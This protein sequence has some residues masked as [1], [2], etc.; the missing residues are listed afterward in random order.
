[1]C[2]LKRLSRTVQYICGMGEKT[3]SQLTSFP[4]PET[5]A[6]ENG[7][8]CN[9]SVS[10]K[11]ESPQRPKN[12]TLE[13]ESRGCFS[14]VFYSS[15]FIMLDVWRQISGYGIKYYNQDKFPVPQT[16]LVAA[17]ELI[18]CF[19]F[20]VKMTMAGTICTVKL[21]P[22]YLIPSLCYAV[23]NNL[24]YLAMYYTTPPVWN[25]L[26]QM[27]VIFTAFVY[28]FYFKKTFS[29]VQWLALTL[30]MVAIVMAKFTGESSGSEERSRNMFIAMLMALGA[31]MIAAMGPVYAEYLLKNDDR[32][33]EEQQLQMYLFGSVCTCSLL[34]AE[35]AIRKPSIQLDQISHLVGILVVLCV[36]FSVACGISTA[37]IMKKL[38]NIVKL[39]SQAIS[40]SLTT[41]ACVFFF[42]KSFQLEGVFMLCL[43]LTF[44]AIFLYENENIDLSGVSDKLSD[45]VQ[46]VTRS[47]L[48]T[49][50]LICGITLLM[51]LV[52]VFYRLRSADGLLELASFQGLQA[53]GTETAVEAPAINK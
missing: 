6:N 17:G 40:N 36:T 2:S 1:M 24:F 44:V 13:R 38:D 22:K 8:V 10:P 12:I 51:S 47:T 53:E 42:P 37:F 4:D 15:V 31:S 14:V 35:T 23:N 48:R 27:R 7:S 19:L 30:L 32:D 43:V 5:L 21:S 33:F 3:D 18:K 34:L 39:Y 46:F 26:T 45:L 52:I 25:I 29:F 50:L 11:G 9:G 20:T 28:R 49:V 16:S 41:V